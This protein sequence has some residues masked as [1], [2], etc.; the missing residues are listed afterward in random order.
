M[1]SRI[2]QVVTLA[3]MNSASNLVSELEN[4]AAII[5]ICLNTLALAATLVALA[6]FTCLAITGDISIRSNDRSS[7]RVVS[8]EERRSGQIGAVALA[9]PFCFLAPVFLAIDSLISPYAEQGAFNGFHRESFG[10]V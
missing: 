6:M 1:Q 2:S 10:T 9:I 7:T 3:K 4:L 5:A 8:E